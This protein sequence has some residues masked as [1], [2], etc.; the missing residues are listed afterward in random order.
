M[1]KT[2]NMIEGNT[3]EANDHTAADLRSGERAKIRFVDGSMALKRR[4][5]AM[6]I[7]SGVEIKLEHTAPFGDPRVYSILGYNLSLRNEDA[8]KIVVCD[9]QPVDL[10]LPSSGAVRPKP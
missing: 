2:E 7:V 6:G 1:Q 4:L 5:S 10:R 8:C 3:G 9:W